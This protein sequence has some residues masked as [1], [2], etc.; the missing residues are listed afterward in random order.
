MLVVLWIIVGLLVIGFVASLPYWLPARVVALRMLVFARVN[1]EEGIP[2]PGKR[3]GLENFRALYAHPAANG[4][5]RGAGLSNLFWYWLAPGPE[6][7]QE[8]LEP[9]PRYDEVARVTRQIL[10]RGKEESERLTRRTVSRVLDELPERTTLTVRLRD[11]MMP[12]WA[13]LYYEL[14]FAEPCPPDARKLIVDNADDVVTALK[15]CGLRHMRTRERLTAYLRRRIADGDIAHPLPASLSPEET[16][17]YLQGTFFNTAVVQMS[18]A[19]THLVLA[20]AEHPEVAARL[21]ADLDDTAYLDRVIDETFR[22]YPLFGIAHRIT[23]ADIEFGADALPAGSVLCFSYPDYHAAGY[24]DAANFDPDRWLRT[25]TKDSNFIPFGI[26]ANRPCPARGLAPVT[27]RVVLR[28]LL[29]RYAVGSSIAHTRSIPNRGPCLLVPR[30]AGR[31]PSRAALARL[32][33]ADRWADVWRSLVQLVLGSYMVWDA[34]RKSL[35]DRYFARTGAPPAP[36]G[37]PV[38]HPGHAD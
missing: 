21:A 27:M 35:S 36:A 26:T 38:I 20:V 22:V 3:I 24:A 17:L 23:T 33:L 37:C 9:G 25:S 5:S 30:A 2:V 15:C 4:R 29:R 10:V 6:V 14:V 8:H 11:L 7:H 28:E 13:E 16:A 12:I 32:R 18:E 34:R 31:A 19:M 1:G